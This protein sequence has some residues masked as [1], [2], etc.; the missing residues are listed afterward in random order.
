MK[1]QFFVIAAAVAITIIAALVQYLSDYSRINPADVATISERHYVYQVKDVLTT[2]ANVTPCDRID[3][4][5]SGIEESLYN[6]FITKGILATFWHDASSCPGTIRLAFNI[7]S[8]GFFS[9][10][11]FEVMR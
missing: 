6:F 10:T 7:T 2:A 3:E 5:L 9:Q 4:E 8:K 1:G 11:A